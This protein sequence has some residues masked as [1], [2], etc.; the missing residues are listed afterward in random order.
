[1]VE[2][3]ANRRATGTDVVRGA[4]YGGGAML[5]SSSRDPAPAL[6]GCASTD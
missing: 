4:G 3:L 6:K 5:R 1:M 2:P